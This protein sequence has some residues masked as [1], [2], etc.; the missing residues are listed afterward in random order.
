M[1]LSGWR[2]HHGIM[3]VLA[4]AVKIIHTCH[5]GQA[6]VVHITGKGVDAGA[7]YS[8]LALQSNADHVETRPL[9][10]LHVSLRGTCKSFL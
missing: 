7:T 3:W 1:K 9:R 2:I 4:S 8:S 6:L 5:I 10:C